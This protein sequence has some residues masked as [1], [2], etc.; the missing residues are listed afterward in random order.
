MNNNNNSIFVTLAITLIG[1]TLIIFLPLIL[2]VCEYILFG[3]MHV[4]DF[5]RKLGIHETLK[6]IYAPIVNIIRGK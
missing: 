5:A 1:L 6:E 3:S 2:S 4:E